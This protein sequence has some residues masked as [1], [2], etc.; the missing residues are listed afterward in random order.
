MPLTNKTCNEKDNSLL[1]ILLALQ[2]LFQ[3]ILAISINVKLK[4]ALK[5]IINLRESDHCK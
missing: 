4:L 3:E 5:S 1:F 2:F